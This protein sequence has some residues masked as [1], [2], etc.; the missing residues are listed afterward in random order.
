MKKKENF[1]IFEK[2][3]KD[4]VINLLVGDIEPNYVTD[5]KDLKDFFDDNGNYNSENEMICMVL[6]NTF[7]SFDP[8]ESLNKIK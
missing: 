3:R 1:E 2:I 4:R 8:I 6:K 7:E 5:N